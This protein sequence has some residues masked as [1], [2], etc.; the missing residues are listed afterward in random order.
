VVQNP[1]PPTV[2]GGT[3]IAVDIG[4]DVQQIDILPGDPAQY[5]AAAERSRLTNAN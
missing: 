3:T 5:H 1:L 4:C 2:E